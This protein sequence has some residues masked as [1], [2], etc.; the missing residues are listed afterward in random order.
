MT[1]DIQAVLHRVVVEVFGETEVEWEDDER[2][3]PHVHCVRL[4]ARGS[5]DGQ[6]RNAA[7]CASYEWFEAH[8]LDFEVGTISFDYDDDEAEK[9][10]EIGDL[11]RIIRAYLQGEGQVTYRPTL[12]RRRLLPTLTIDMDGT[13]WHFRGRTSWKSPL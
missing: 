12:F 9:E 10:V 2:E 11:A 3:A 1:I 4:R 6:E 7:L 13:R 8:L 5:G